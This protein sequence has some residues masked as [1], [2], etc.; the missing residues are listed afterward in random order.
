MKSTRSA[1]SLPVTH[2]VQSP[3]V[4]VLSSI[5]NDFHVTLSVKSWVLTGAKRINLSSSKATGEILNYLLKHLTIQQTSINVTDSEE[6]LGGVGWGH[7]WHVH[8]GYGGRGNQGGGC[9][10]LY[11]QRGHGISGSFP[12]GSRRGAQSC[13]EEPRWHDGCCRVGLP[14]PRNSLGRVGGGTCRVRKSI[15]VFPFQWLVTWTVLQ[16]H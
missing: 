1:R 15:S 4:H 12:A 11:G 16:V 3:P 14:E 7:T 10:L 13:C 5:Y 8:C 9:L 6:A 2:I